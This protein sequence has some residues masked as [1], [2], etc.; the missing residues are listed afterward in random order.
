MYCNT[1]QNTFNKNQGTP[2]LDDPQASRIEQAPAA[3]GRP[4]GIG[5]PRGCPPTGW[6][7]W[8]RLGAAC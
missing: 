6:T 1:H 8:G 5:G 3:L 7:G 2:Y 4:S